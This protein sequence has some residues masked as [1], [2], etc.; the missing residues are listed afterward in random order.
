MSTSQN[1]RQ[2]KNQTLPFL[3]EKP[4]R[5]AVFCRNGCHFSMVASEHDYH[6]CPACH[7]E[8]ST[9]AEDAYMAALE[10]AGIMQ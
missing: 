2:A 7:S 1:Q 9:S 10:S 3:F 5:V 8:M 6:Q 4:K